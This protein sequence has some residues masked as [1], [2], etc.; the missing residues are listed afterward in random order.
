M[1]CFAVIKNS[2]KIKILKSIDKKKIYIF[3]PG[4]MDLSN[5][6]YNNNFKKWCALSVHLTYINYFTV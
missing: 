6:I 5:T 3:I 2:Y 4:S 1:V